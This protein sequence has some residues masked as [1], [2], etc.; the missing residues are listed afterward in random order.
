MFQGTSNPMNAY[1]LAATAA[2]LAHASGLHRW[3]DDFGF[4]EEQADERRNVFWVLYILDKGICLQ[5]GRP[6]LIH[7]QDIGVALPKEEEG[8]LFP[9][10][11]PKF[12]TFRIAAKLAM[13]ESRVYSELYSARSQTKSPLQKLKAVGEFDS[14]LEKWRDSIPIEIR[15]DYEILCDDHQLLP[16]IVLHY[17]YYNCLSAVHRVSIGYGPWSSESTKYDSIP[18]DI[19]LNPRVYESEAIHV[20]SARSVISL[21]D[22]FRRDRPPPMI[23]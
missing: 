15:P 22:H 3:L 6:P 18:S 10:G 17:S 4:S 12:N 16:V 7:D 14:A 11:R 19:Q 13:I 8:K 5:S 20:E 23:W 21:L 1:T 2:R 9:S